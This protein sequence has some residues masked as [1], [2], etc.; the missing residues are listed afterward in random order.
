MSNACGRRDLVNQVQPDEELRLPVGQL[1][2]GVGVPD[3]LSRVAGIGSRWYHSSGARRLA[4]LAARGRGRWLD[5]V[6]RI[7][8]LPPFTQHSADQ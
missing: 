2:D 4:V 1:P 7:F 5:S 6:R 3:F 8:D